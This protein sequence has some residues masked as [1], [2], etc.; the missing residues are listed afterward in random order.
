[1]D[2]VLKEY[3]DMKEE[4]KRTTAFKSIYKAMLSYGLKCRKNTESKN[5][6]DSLKKLKTNEV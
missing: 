3:D 5:P 2:N 4:M 6:F 1:M